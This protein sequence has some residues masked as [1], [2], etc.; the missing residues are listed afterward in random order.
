M[1]IL[2]GF[3]GGTGGVGL[4]APSHAGVDAAGRVATLM[5]MMEDAENSKVEKE[6]S[7]LGI[8][9]AEPGKVD[10]QQAATLNKEIL[11]LERKIGLIKGFITFWKDI[12]K[13]GIDL[14]A[15]FNELIK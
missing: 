11:E 15:Q 7:L 8:K 2:D 6:N 4:S 14:L 9:S 13:A 5:T 3:F 12:I 1:F 10:V